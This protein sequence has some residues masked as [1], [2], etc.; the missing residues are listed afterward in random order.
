MAH[1]PGAPDPMDIQDRKEFSR[2][3]VEGFSGLHLEVE[4]WW[5]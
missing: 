4:G 2:P 1:F 3:F 5:P